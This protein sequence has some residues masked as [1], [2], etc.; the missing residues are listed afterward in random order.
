MKK[1]PIPINLKLAQISKNQEKELLERK[2][3][4]INTKIHKIDRSRNCQTPNAFRRWELIK[5]NLEFRSEL[6]KLI[7]HFKI[8]IMLKAYLC[9]KRKFNITTRLS[10]VAKNLTNSTFWSLESKVRRIIQEMLI[11][12][13][14]FQNKINNEFFNS[15]VHPLK[16][17]NNVVD[18]HDKIKNRRKRVQKILMHKRQK[19]QKEKEIIKEDNLR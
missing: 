15:Q 13:N 7:K 1:S 9:I 5:P 6:E 12:K 10:I 4:E 11:N 18:I 19:N 17:S 3:E 2:Q 16:R 8:K 14:K